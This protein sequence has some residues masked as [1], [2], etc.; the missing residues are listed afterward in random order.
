MPVQFYV[1]FAQN[2]NSELSY[3]RRS[4]PLVLTDF[5]KRTVKLIRN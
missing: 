5:L 3:S 1:H 2:W 4:L